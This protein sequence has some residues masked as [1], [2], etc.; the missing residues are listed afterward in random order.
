M[1]PASG[2]TMGGLMSLEHIKDHSFQVGRFDIGFPP[3]AAAAVK[4][5]DDKVDVPSSFGTI[6]G[7]SWTYA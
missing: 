3:G 7:S 4:V 5:V 1:N 6:E 2:K